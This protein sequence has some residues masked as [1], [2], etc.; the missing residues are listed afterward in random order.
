[1]MKKMMV[2]VGMAAMLLCGCGKEETTIVE[3]EV[4]T[5]SLVEENIEAIED[6]TSKLAEEIT[7]MYIEA[8]LEIY[9]D[10]CDLDKVSCDNDG[11][12]YEGRFVSWEYLEEV[13]Y[14]SMMNDWGL[15]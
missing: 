2:L 13:A 15:I 7:N 10:D 3:T 5:V 6:S 12:T 14:N 8:T 11:L 1:M 9:G 4:E